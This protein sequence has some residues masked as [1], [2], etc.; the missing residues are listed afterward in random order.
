MLQF[1][2]LALENVRETVRFFFLLIYQRATQT[3]LQI[4]DYMA[5]GKFSQTKCINTVEVK[6][7]G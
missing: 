5:A 7:S 3:A 2:L 4:P 6:F 1:L